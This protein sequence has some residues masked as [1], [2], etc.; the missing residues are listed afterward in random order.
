MYDAQ[1][2][3]PHLLVYDSHELLGIGEGTP[4][5]RTTYSPSADFSKDSH[6][7]ALRAII[8]S[9]KLSAAACTSTST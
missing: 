7:S 2:T 4:Y 1:R 6:G 3:R 9:R 5:S 8:M